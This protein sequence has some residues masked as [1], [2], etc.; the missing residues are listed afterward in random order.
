[1]LLTP[2]EHDADGEDLLGIGVWRYVTE[3][4]AGQAAEREV[5]G[6]HVLGMLVGPALGV[7]VAVRAVNAVRQV[8]QPAH[9]PI[10]APLQVANRVPDA[11]EPMSQQ[12]KGAH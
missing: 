8:I 12:G 5:Q 9:G 10:T 7:R 3:A 6:R 2:N 11:G 1:M 4:H